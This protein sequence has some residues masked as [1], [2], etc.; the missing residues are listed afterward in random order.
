MPDL[1]Q[2]RIQLDTFLYPIGPT[3]YLPNLRF[4]ATLSCTLVEKAKNQGL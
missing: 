1:V 2:Q 3:F 4:G